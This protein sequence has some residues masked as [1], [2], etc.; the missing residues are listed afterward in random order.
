[1]M[2]G[3]QLAVLSG[4]LLGLGL[5]LVVARLLPAE[6]DL[7]DALDRV[8][9]PRRGAAARAATARTRQE[10]LG[11]WGLRTLPPGLW[12]RTPTRE[13]ALLRISVGQFYGEKL[14]FAGLGLFIPPGLTVLFNTLGLGIPLQIPALAS[15]GLASLMFFIPNYNALDDARKARVEFARA[16]GAYID[17]VALERHNGIGVR[18]AMEAAAEVGDSWVFT[19]LSEELTRSRWSGL[20]PWEALH[21]LAEELGLPELDDF[22]DIM[23]LSGEEGASVYATLRARSAAMRTARLNDEIA[24]ANAVGERMTIPGS[25][26]G[27]IFMALLVAP[28]L[29]RMLTSP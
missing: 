16:L 6:P 12:V 1:M 27:V 5:V 17:L 19:R 4:G 8:S 3:L 10:R 2:T 23:R 18:Q 7:A 21:T 22:A 11:L 28:S 14:T 20:P 9:S 15:L 24:E 26:L 25:L 29:L 13:L